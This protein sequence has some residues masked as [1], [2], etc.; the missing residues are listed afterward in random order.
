MEPIN[1]QKSKERRLRRTDYNDRRKGVNFI[2]CGLNT[3]V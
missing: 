1:L 2:F 3:I